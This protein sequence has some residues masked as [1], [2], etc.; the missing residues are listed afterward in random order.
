M[1]RRAQREDRITEYS[2]KFC[3]MGIEK[4]KGVHKENFVS[5]SKT[6]KVSRKRHLQ[7]Y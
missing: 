6:R 5:S 3:Q 1:Q 7:I 4:V 2:V